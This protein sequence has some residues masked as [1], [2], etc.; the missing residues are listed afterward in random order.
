MVK[1]AV[2]SPK[3]GKLNNQKG[4]SPRQYLKESVVEL[5]KVIWPTKNQVI[6]MTG[7][8][9]GVSLVTGLLIGG[10]D[11]LFTNLIGLIIQ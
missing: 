10:L 3:G 6:K 7:V 1:S 9:I 11:L 4:T 5:K 8:V 2:D